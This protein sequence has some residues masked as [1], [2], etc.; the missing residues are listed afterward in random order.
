MADVN[1]FSCRSLV[2]TG[3]Q[4]TVVSL[5]VL[6]S[7]G[8]RYIKQRT[9]VTMLD[10]KTTECLGEVELCIVVDGKTVNVRC[11]VSETLVCG[12]SLIMG[13]D[14]IRGLGGLYV[15][16]EG[17]PRFEEMNET[18]GRPVVAVGE[19]SKVQVDDTDFTALFDGNK[20]TVRW[21]W[22]DSEPTLRN[23]CAQ[24]RIDEECQEEYE[25]EMG[26]WIQ[27]GW[28]E[29]HNES[30]HGTVQGVIPLMAAFQPNKQRKVR[31]VMDYGKELNQYI[32]C[33]PGADVAVC[34]DK[35]REW[36]KLGTNCCILDLKKAYLQLHVDQELQ[37]FQAIRYGGKLF[38][39]TRMGFGLN[40]A[41]KI[42]SKVLSYVL[43][44]D[45]D[46][47]AGTDHYIDDI[48][49]DLNKVSASQVREHLAKYGLVTKEPE[50]IR[51]A[52]VLGLRVKKSNS[53]KLGWSRDNSL[54]HDIDS[55]TKR[56]LFSLCGKLVGHYPVGGWLR[57][58]CSYIKR[59]VNECKW[60]E[61]IPEAVNW[62]VSEVL[63]RVQ[64][65]DPVSGQW[66]V[67]DNREGTVWCDAS[68]LAIGASVEID[69]EQ[70]ED[71]S[72]LRKDDGN[73]INV[74][75]L[76]GVIRGIS[77]AV[78]WNIKKLHVMTDSA[79]VYSWVKSIIAN[80]K[81]PKVCGLGEMLIRRRLSMIVELVE[82]YS[83][84]VEMKL[85]RSEE[86]KADVLTRV[87][88]SW[89]DRKVCVAVAQQGI[90]GSIQ[91]IR[92]LH[93]THHLGVARTLY[94]A[95]QKWGPSV[96]EEDV[97]RVVSEC[98]I[99]KRID[100]APVRW[101]KGE[102]AVNLNW[103]RLATDITHYNGIPYLTIIDCGPSRFSLWRTLR[104]ETAESVVKVIEQVF[105]ERGAPKEILSDNGPC[106]QS[107]RMKDL[108]EKWGV[109]HVF[110]CAYRASGNGIIERHHRTI[111]R[112]M[113]RTGKGVQEMLYWY[114]FSPKVDGVIPADEIYRNEKYNTPDVSGNSFKPRDTSLNPFKL[115]DIVY[116]KP[117]NSRCTTPWKI[118][119]VTAL[120]SNTALQV[121]S[122][123]RHIGDVRLCQPGSLPSGE[124]DSKGV[125]QESEDGVQVGSSNGYEEDSD[126]S[127][128]GS[129]EILTGDRQEQH[130]ESDVGEDNGEYGD[131]QS[132]DNNGRRAIRERKPPSWLADFCLL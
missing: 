128:A 20:W 61:P 13:M 66:A 122:M 28:L 22:K 88:K 43:G 2:D 110:S 98:H 5:G 59:Q 82:L 45:K 55:L 124:S 67:A 4:Q 101:E 100:P 27:D 97:A 56:K 104:N 39:M 25:S 58:A 95:R 9:T 3:C 48:I 12:C 57:V 114:N 131:E 85:V 71:G 126:M 106:Y 33:N 11:L 16:S 54:D 18:K 29:E 46:V 52:R 73:H 35:L 14:V 72:W 123:T 74:A 112:M 121:D 109:E 125:R 119:R 32:N 99:C 7:I 79:T 70:V 84:E 34:Q 113:A 41:P 89:L 96:C 15:S 17:V 44:L 117:H 10:G 23:Q 31:P 91:D 127:E 132:C 68:K 47:H 103:T 42:M 115:N 63:D 62:M 49:V 40:V 69:G 81:R 87:P 130:D 38:V 6:K 1:G 102:L 83:L 36:R 111:K 92:D 90:Q 53:G 80:S 24:Y 118:G 64:S 30:I 75:E 19:S 51:D 129:D 108:L 116:V 93:D 86:N 120:V 50:S 26:Q 78:K 105:Y 60:D 76:D 77:L 21:K 107:Q 37:K 94:L 65:K 8:T